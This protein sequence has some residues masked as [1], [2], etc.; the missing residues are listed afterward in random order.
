MLVVPAIFPADKPEHGAGDDGKAEDVLY[1]PLD[2][3]ELRAVAADGEAHD[4]RGDGKVRRRF[5]QPLAVAGRGQLF[6]PVRERHTPRSLG[7]LA[8]RHSSSLPVNGPRATS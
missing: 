1:P 5:A 8:V 6:D 7:L 3:V 4:G 2:E